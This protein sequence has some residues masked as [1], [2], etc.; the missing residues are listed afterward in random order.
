ME[1][2]PAAGINVFYFSNLIFDVAIK[3]IPIMPIIILVAKGRIPKNIKTA[4]VKAKTIPIINWI[5]FNVFLAIIFN[6]KNKV[7]NTFVY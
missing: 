2:E 3:A 7:Y 1:Q 6:L 4:L 5:R